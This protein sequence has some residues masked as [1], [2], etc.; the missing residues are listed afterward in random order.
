MAC[1]GGN[2]ERAVGVLEAL[3]VYGL[4]LPRLPAASSGGRRR[5]WL[6]FTLIC[7]TATNLLT[8]SFAPGPP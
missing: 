3:S 6:E 2:D 1:L 4:T 7:L 5:V 8:K